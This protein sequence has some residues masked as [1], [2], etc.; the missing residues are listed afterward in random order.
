MSLNRDLVEKF[1]KTNALIYAVEKAKE[2]LQAS[3]DELKH[4]KYSAGL[5]VMRAKNHME[6][7]RRAIYKRPEGGTKEQKREVMRRHEAHDKAIE[8]E[9]KFKKI[10]ERLETEVRKAEKAYFDHLKEIR[11][12]CF[13]A[14]V[15]AQVIEPT[16]GAPKPIPPPNSI[17]FS[18]MKQ[19]PACPR[20]P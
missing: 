7:A 12:L 4:S 19:V 14:F 3:E 18:S 13:G 20:K 1:R 17:P 6:A 10:L 2:S 9:N 16:D 15:E 11:D 8:K 5:E